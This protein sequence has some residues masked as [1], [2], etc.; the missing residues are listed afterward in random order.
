MLLFE[1]HDRHGF[2]LVFVDL[3]CQSHRKSLDAA[4]AAHRG[5]RKAGFHALVF[6]ADAL[7]RHTHLCLPTLFGGWRRA[8]QFRQGLG[9]RNHFLAKHLTVAPGNEAVDKR[10]GIDRPSAVIFHFGLIRAKH[11]VPGLVHL[12]DDST[13][14][15]YVG[16]D[17]PQGS[18]EGG[19]CG[20]ARAGERY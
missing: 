2:G 6:A 19:D 3:I 4:L 1:A 12:E 13:G 11:P 5:G 9:Y 7:Q 14:W 10:E 17:C 20:Q 16:L 15:A 8:V 18:C